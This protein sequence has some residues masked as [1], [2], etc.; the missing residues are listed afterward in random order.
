MP[1]KG[2]K[3]RT[4]QT[5]AAHRRE[6]ARLYCDGLNQAEIGR[7]LGLSQPQISRELAALHDQWIAEQKDFVH[8][9]KIRELS[10]LDRLEAELWD[11][12]DRSKQEAEKFA[13]KDGKDGNETTYTIEQRDGNPAFLAGVQ[14]CIAER[15]KILGLY[16]PTKTLNANANFTPG[17]LTGGLQATVAVFAELG[18]GDAKRSNPAS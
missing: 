4:P 18:I 7:L 1:A 14:S 6:V 15:C 11:A 17:D 13:D 2:R 10:R 9:Y 12:W 5:V 3:K 8:R 16:A